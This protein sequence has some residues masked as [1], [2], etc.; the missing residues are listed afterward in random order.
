MNW[1]L[2]K[3]SLLVSGGAALLASSLG[4]AA[5]LWLAGMSRGARRLFTA[6]AIV[7]L[8]LPGFVVT[9]CWLFFLGQTG[10]WRGWLPFNI[11][12]LGGTVWILGLM[13]W[14]IPLLSV[15]G[16]WQRLEPQLLESDMAV[17]GRY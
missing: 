14:P 11:M 10:I 15:L 1:L 5:A 12:S 6:L 3:N 16:A 2:V 9:N 17:R 7:T 13:L 4:F 8:A